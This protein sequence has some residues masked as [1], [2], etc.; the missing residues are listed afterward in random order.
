MESLQCKFKPHISSLYRLAHF[1]TR[2]RHIRN[3][4]LKFKDDAFDRILWEL[5]F[6]RGMDLSQD[7]LRNDL[8]LKLRKSCKCLFYITQAHPELP[9]GIV[10]FINQCLL[11]C[12]LNL[13]LLST[14][15]VINVILYCLSMA[16]LYQARV[17]K[18]I[19]V[20]IVCR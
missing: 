20:V 14:L 13:Y 15:N 19:T 4:V 2:Q 8:I 12:Q 7:R 1:T 10:Y 18:E 9:N 5:A 17:R 6:E 16:A 3:N 11:K